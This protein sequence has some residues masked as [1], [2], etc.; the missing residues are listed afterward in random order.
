MELEDKIRKLINIS[1]KTVILLK[2]KM[3]ATH[4]KK[5]LDLLIKAVYENQ[6]NIFILS[7]IVGDLDGL[8]AEYRNDQLNIF[9]INIKESIKEAQDLLK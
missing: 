4:S 3:N 7:K 2:R 5:E 8:K 6:S 9:F 1:K